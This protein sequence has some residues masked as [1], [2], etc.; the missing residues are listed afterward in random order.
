MFSWGLWKV[1]G[2]RERARE[3]ERES[4]SEYEVKRAA[5]TNRLVGVKFIH[6]IQ[7]FLSNKDERK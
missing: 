6:L 5:V 4:E 2:M 1:D 7:S 3:R